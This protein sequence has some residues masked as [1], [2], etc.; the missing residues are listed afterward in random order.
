M[1]EVTS[2]P[3]FYLSRSADELVLKVGNNPIQEKYAGKRVLVIGGGVT[4]LT[5][6][7][8]EASS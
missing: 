1:V 7:N 5:V 3:N 2:V 8:V 6:C 4:G